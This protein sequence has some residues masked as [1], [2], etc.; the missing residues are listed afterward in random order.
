MQLIFYIN[1]QNK[2]KIN[3]HKQTPQ[4][5]EA[6]MKRDMSNFHLEYLVEKDNS[7]QKKN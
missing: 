4:S 6:C 5:T 3:R 1:L 7:V 2:S